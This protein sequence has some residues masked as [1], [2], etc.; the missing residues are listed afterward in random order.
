VVFKLT[1]PIRKRGAWTE[2]VLHGFLGGNDGAF[3]MAGVI[4]DQNG[5]L[6]G[7]TEF[8]GPSG[9]GTVFEIDP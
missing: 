6:Y 5:S 9:L 4:V 8:G 3:P 7:T 1:P 2:V